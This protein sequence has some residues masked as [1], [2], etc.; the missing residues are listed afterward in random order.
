[1][2]SETDALLQ[3]L[4]EQRAA[5]L[6]IIEGLDDELLTGKVLPFGWS[7]IGL[8]EHLG[9]AE[10]FWFQLVATGSAADLPWD[11]TSVMPD[12]NPLAT[13]RSPQVVLSFYREQCRVAN[14]VLRSTPLTTPPV[15]PIGD[16]TDDEVPDLRWIAL[17]M[18]EETARHAGH[19]DIVRQ[20]LD[21]QTG[22]GPR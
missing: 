9:H 8:I 15:G 16:A 17:H 10:R 19:L 13:S 1:V 4:D 14:D 11:D 3:F 6:A 7:P 22:L 20:L 12:P 21:G 5:V 18:I 2:P